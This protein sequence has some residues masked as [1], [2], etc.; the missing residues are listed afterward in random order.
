MRRASS[1]RA[2]VR[3]LGLG[4]AALP[5][6]PLLPSHAADAAPP[7]RVV[8]VHFAHGVAVDQWRPAV[9]GGSLMLSPSLMPLEAFRD[10]LTVI[11]GLDNAVG[12]DQLGDV[13]NIA[14][15]T[16]LTAMPLA[17]DQGPGG[18]YLPG[19]PSIDA[20]IGR[21]LAEDAGPDASAHRTMHFGVRSQGFA[22][23][24]ADR[25]LPLRAEDDP[26]QMY[27]R[28]FGELALD[29]EARAR[30][31]ADRAEIRSFV[32]EQLGSLGPTL[33]AEDRDKLAR[34]DEAV[35]AIEA[36][37]AQGHEPPVSCVLPDPS[38]EIP[39]APLPDNDDVPALV[40]AQ[41]DLLVAALACD[42]TRVATV[43]WGSSGNDGLRHTWQ[44]I[45][46]DYHSIAHL[47][48]GEDPVA[49]QQ[50]AD[51]NRWYAQQVASLLAKLDGVDEGD[52]TLLDHT[53][54][55][56]LSGLS[57]VHAMTDLPVVIAG[58]GIAGDRRLD[59]AGAPCA[60][61]WRALAEHMAVE[62]EGFGD[63]DYDVGV[64]SGL[65]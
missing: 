37:A 33:P 43:Q 12:A 13:H 21:R 42:L 8:F 38:P 36:R 20:V 52:G 39:D 56:F 58:G 2:F 61:L 4:A 3:S 9:R 32:R 25:E 59:A 22:L 50:L 11:E 15:G 29:P 45:D 55:V 54:V 46:V 5:W 63:P 18:H 51:M 16:L 64:L 47:A 30:R 14:L 49:H 24:A 23:A 62:L 48:N 60:A 26:A 7:R 44:G 1:R 41:E 40:T 19:G 34:H 6:L 57:V 27:A 53:T 10:R 35:Q 31:Q 17:T 28:I 65:L